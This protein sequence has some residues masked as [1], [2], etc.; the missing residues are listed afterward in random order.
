[1][2]RVEKQLQALKDCYGRVQTLRSLP[3]GLLSG[4]KQMVWLPTGQFG[5]LKGIGE[6]IR[7]EEVQEALRAAEASEKADGNVGIDVRRKQR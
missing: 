5:E 7:S 1:M 6:M 4:P 3:Q 2:S